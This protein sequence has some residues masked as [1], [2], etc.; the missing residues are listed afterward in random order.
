MLA[1]TNLRVLV[2][3]LLLVGCAVS[4]SDTFLVKQAELVT[5]SVVTV[6]PSLRFEPARSYPALVIHNV[7]PG[8][9]TVLGYRWYSPGS[10]NAIDDEGFEKISIEISPEMLPLPGPTAVELPS[11]GH[12]AYTRGGAA[13]PRSACYGI[14]T[15][16]SV[17]LSHVAE[18]RA[19]VS[20]QATVEPI[21]ESGDHCDPVE[22]DR[23]FEAETIEYRALTP[24]LGIA[25]DH[26]Y[27]ETHR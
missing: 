7:L 5:H 1:V 3:L 21:R 12:L 23:D 2:L 11:Q 14:A 25:G 22:L 26:P 10:L 19:T 20:I 15:A 16:G 4:R 13:W 6:D 17:T 8:Q 18:N 24:W 9:H 27:A